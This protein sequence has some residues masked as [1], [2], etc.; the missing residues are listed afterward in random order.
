MLQAADEEAPYGVAPPVPRP[1]SPP[2]YAYACVLCALGT[3][4]RIV[5]SVLLVWGIVTMLLTFRDV[6][7]CARALRPWVGIALSSLGACS[8]ME[9][10]RTSSWVQDMRRAPHTCASLAPLLAP[11]GAAVLSTVFLAELCPPQAGLLA[12]CWTFVAFL[13]LVPALLAVVW[14]YAQ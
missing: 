8:L 7:H 9:M 10:Q 5:P 1:S 6:P 11:L 13:Y 3:L 12:W 4:Q 14:Y 2:T